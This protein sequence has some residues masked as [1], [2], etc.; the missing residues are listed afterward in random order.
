M[1]WT[2]A[3][4]VAALVVYLGL[5]AIALSGATSLIEPLVIPL[6]LAVMVALG[7]WLNRF[8]GV[9]PR[10]QHFRDPEDDATS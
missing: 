5:W 9:A 8:M 4:L 1:S 10:E 3:T 7:V 6:A 2:R